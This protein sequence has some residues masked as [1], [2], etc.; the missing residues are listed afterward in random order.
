MKL[1]E[2]SAK[3]A[4]NHV[5]FI[6]KQ[7]PYAAG[8]PHL[9]RTVSEWEVWRDAKLTVP[10]EPNYLWK[11]I[12]NDHYHVQSCHLSSSSLQILR[13]QQKQYLALGLSWSW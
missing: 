2:K 12:Y 5:Y 4:G 6:P 1:C 7:L 10:G 11:P 13:E 8:L 3:G 9:F